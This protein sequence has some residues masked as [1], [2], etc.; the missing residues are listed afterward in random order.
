MNSEVVVAHFQENLDWLKDI[1]DGVSVHVYHKG[2]GLIHLPCRHLPCRGYTRL[3]NRGREAQTYL[4]HIVSRYDSLADVTLFCQ[5]EVADHLPE[6]CTITS[7]LDIGDGYDVRGGFYVR[8]LVEWDQAGRMVHFGK[9][10][11]ACSRGEMR[12]HPYSFTSWWEKFVTSVVPA[13]TTGPG[14]SYF[15]GSVFSVRAEAIRRCPRLLYKCLLDQ[16]SDHPNPEEAYFLE[17]AWTYLFGVP[18]DRI[19]YAT[20]R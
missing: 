13:D 3:D 16:V 19:Q 17:R 14:I 5:G 11:Q 2:S 18:K 8:N 15:V 1:P 12:L 20:T 7:L 10:A 9:W 4:H 6:G